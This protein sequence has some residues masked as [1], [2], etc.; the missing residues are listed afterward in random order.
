MGIGAW[1]LRNSFLKA[2]CTHIEALKYLY[3]DPF[4]AQVSTIEVHGAF[5]FVDLDFDEPCLI[6]RRRF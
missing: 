3:R 2:P 1:G 6:G 4:K 5:G